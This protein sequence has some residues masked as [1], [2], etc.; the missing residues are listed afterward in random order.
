MKGIDGNHLS[1]IGSCLGNYVNQ[2]MG[3][4]CKFYFLSSW[5][6]TWG[7]CA[8]FIFF[9]PEIQNQIILSWQ[10][11][12]LSELQVVTSF[13]PSR[14]NMMCAHLMES[15]HMPFILAVPEHEIIFRCV[16]SGWQWVDGVFCWMQCVNFQYIYV[17]RGKTCCS[18]LCTR[19]PAPSVSFKEQYTE[20]WKNSEQVHCWTTQENKNVKFEL[21]R[22]LH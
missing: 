7:L 8:N 3:I 16:M 5:T 4:I 11:V 9:H 17:C 19:H 21:D 20:Y 6:K 13:V 10:I 14:R 12:S 2:D 1:V 15:V 18:E 22:S